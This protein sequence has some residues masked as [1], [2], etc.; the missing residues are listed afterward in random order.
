MAVYRDSVTVLG[1]KNLNEADKLVILFGYNK[2]KFRAIAKGVRKLSSRKR[3]HVELFSLSRIACAEGKSLDILVEAE[4]IFHLDTESMDTDEFERI[5]FTVYV[6]SKFLP[7]EVP[8]KDIFEK[9]VSYVKS[10]HDL[11]KTTRFVSYILRSLGFLT[12][13]REER[14]ITGSAKDMERLRRYVE[15]ILDTI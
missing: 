9:W 7:D 12:F 8:E 1:S 10:D 4:C 2:G 14:L 13:E 5:G 15:K 6:L 11:E 3:G